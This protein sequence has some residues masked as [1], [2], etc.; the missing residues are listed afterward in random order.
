M[1]TAWQWGNSGPGEGAGGTLLPLCPQMLW[2]E[3]GSRCADGQRGHV[4]RGA[5]RP[6]WEAAAT[7]VMQD[8]VFASQRFLP[9]LPSLP[10]VAFPWDGTSPQTVALNMCRGALTQPPRFRHG[11]RKRLPRHDLLGEERWPF[12]PKEK[13]PEPL[14]PGAFIRF[15]PIGIWIKLINHCQPVRV[16]QHKI[17]REL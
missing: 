1:R 10:S 13:G 9:S 8:E 2:S 17:Y 4:W 3:G 16:K 6:L 5:A 14:S 11:R 12:L 15:I 7:W